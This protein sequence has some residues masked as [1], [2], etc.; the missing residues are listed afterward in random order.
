MDA[1]FPSME[2]PGEKLADKYLRFVHHQGSE[3]TISYPMEKYLQISSLTI[4]S[5]RMLFLEMFQA[6]IGTMS[7]HPRG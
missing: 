2:S 1:R 4:V 5:F 6:I 7:R 3:L